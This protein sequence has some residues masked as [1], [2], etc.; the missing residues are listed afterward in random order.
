MV[1]E[2]RKQIKHMILAMV[3]GNVDHYE[4]MWEMPVEDFL[5]K[6][7]PYTKH[8]QYQQRQHKELEKQI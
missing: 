7:D 3:D 2:K 6:A 1:I 5:I 4:T 8:V